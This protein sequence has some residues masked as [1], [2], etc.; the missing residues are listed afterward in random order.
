MTATTKLDLELL[1]NSAANQT[2]ANETFHQLNQLVQASVVDRATTPPGSPANEAL[3]LI[4]ATATGIWA[5][6]ENQLAYWLTSTSAW[7]Y[8]TPREGM[9]VHVNDED[10]YYSFDGSAWAVFSGGGGGGVSLPV[11]QALSSTRNLALADINTFNVNSTTNNYTVTIPPQAS[12]AWT[13][14]AEI[15]FLPSNTGDIT[16]TGGTGVSVNGVVA[17]SIT[18][19]TAYG[20]ASIKRIAS[21]SWWVGGALNQSEISITGATTLTDSA[22]GSMQVCTGT[23]VDY[24]VTLPAAAGNAGK[25]IQIRMSSA[26]TKLVTVDGNG[27]ETIDGVASRVMRA[28]ESAVF[29]CDGTGWAITNYRGN[30][31]R[32]SAVKTANQ[33]VAATAFTKVTFDSEEYD[34]GGAFDLANSRFICARAGT[35]AIAGGIAVSFTASGDSGSFRIYKNGAQVRYA[36][37]ASVSAST[38]AGMSGSAYLQLA[39]GDI[40]E[41]YIYNGS[42]GARDVVGNATAGTTVLSISEVIAP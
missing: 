33:S 12:V 23:T 21:D 5:G 41:S 2:L 31:F 1:Q 36:A 40:I 35:Y 11:V 32:A 17:G 18:L 4:I 37:F 28:S 14:D 34:F 38:T 10:D 19:S 20:A 15:H 30:P 9:L 6:K 39:V 27:S 22:F 42:P 26:L 7:Q 13:A 3:Y 29:L 25:S 16:I 24:T 8:I